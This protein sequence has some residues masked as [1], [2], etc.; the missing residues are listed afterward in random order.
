MPMKTI[1]ISRAQDQNRRA[2]IQ[3]SIPASIDWEFLD[4]SDGH[5]PNSIGTYYE[6]LIPMTFWHNDR[7]KPGAFGCFVSHY[8]A[9]EDC[10][11]RNT[12]VLI[13]EDD[14]TFCK[15]DSIIKE[16]PDIND[17][18]LIFVN[19]AAVA[20]N[21]LYQ[22]YRGASYCP[23]TTVRKKIAFKIS[24]TRADRNDGEYAA[25]SELREVVTSLTRWSITPD[26]HDAPGAY[27]YIVTPAGAQK[28]LVLSDSLGVVVGVDWFMLGSSMSGTV[29]SGAWQFPGK[30][31]LYFLNSIQL[32]A[33][34]SSRW[35]VDSNDFDIGGSV[36]NHS[37]MMP[38][39]EYEALL[40]RPVNS[41]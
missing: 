2:R 30:V 33:G 41:A 27:G 10:L 31:A 20:W 34:V 15:S 3:A 36:I 26:S 19:R 8:R 16:I 12:N 1:V 32:R 22:A 18:D 13:L 24:R 5:R 25:V 40:S 23:I 17:W 9:W 11:Q 39:K 21:L 37:E 38:I 4:A 35:L 14:V 29:P 6:K 7:I 28:L